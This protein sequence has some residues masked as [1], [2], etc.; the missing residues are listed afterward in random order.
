[1]AIFN[2]KLLNCQRVASRHILSTY[3]FLVEPISCQAEQR[4]QA[5]LQA[6]QRVSTTA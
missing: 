2:S 5:L 6:A 1:M 4:N 3:S